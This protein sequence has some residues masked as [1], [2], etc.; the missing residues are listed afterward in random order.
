M[1]LVT[2]ACLADLGHS[3][4][5]IDRD[6]RRIATL[7]DGQ[8]PF[9]E[10]GLADLVA[11]GR[12]S[13]RL[14]FSLAIADAQG[15]QAI[16][17]GVGTPPDPGSGHADLSAVFAVAGEIASV[18]SGFTVVVCKS[19]VPVGTGD[20]IEDILGSNGPG[21]QFAAVSNPE[22][23]R[24]GSA[25][26]DFMM[27]D[28][29]VVGTADARAA[30]IMQEIYQPLTAK[31]VPLVVT[32]RRSS[33]LSKYAGNAFL[34]M[35]VAFINEIADLCESSG[36]DVGDVARI[37][38]LDSRIGEK[39]LRA[40]P[41]FGGSCFPKDTL[42]LIRTARELSTPLHLI[43]TTI[44][45]NS[46]RTATMIRKISAALGGSVAGK[47]VGVW[48]LTFK[49][50]TDDMRESPAVP[51]IDGLIEAGADVQAY[52]PEGMANARAAGSRARLCED[53]YDAAAGA[54]ALVLITEWKTFHHPDFARLKALM[55]GRA[56]VDLR[57]ALPREEA[58]VHGFSYAGVGRGTAGS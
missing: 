57:N 43:E 37:I 40:G 20:R 53:Q 38:G 5:C 54:D 33:E 25:I 1:G 10:P 47:T 24:E 34:A 52:D 13:G 16:F 31:G 26:H 15:C 18:I 39:F 35:K 32:G 55:R 2:G 28:R 9:F 49:P 14:R 4:L 8:V 30:A 36:G 7:E 22:F 12:T 45:S 41:G 48:G 46:A 51:I 56:I 29:I 23:L 21:S 58:L 17:I 50:D 6:A 42:S 44:G 19:T 27:P 3:V 11:R